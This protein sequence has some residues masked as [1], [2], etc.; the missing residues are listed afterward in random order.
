MTKLKVGMISL[1]CNKN[2]VDSETA[3]GLLREHGYEL[4]NDPAQ[5]DVLMVNTC[6]FIASAKEESIDAIL[7]MARYKQIGKCRVLLFVPREGAATVLATYERARTMPNT[8]VDIS[9]Y[10][11]MLAANLVDVVRGC[12]RLGVGLC[13]FT[14]IENMLKEEGAEDIACLPAE[15]LVEALRMIKEPKEIAALR[16]VAAFTDECMATICDMLRPGVTQWEVEN[17]LNQLGLEHGCSDVPFSPSCTFTKTGDPRCQDKIGTIPKDEP[18]TPGTAIAFDNGFVMDG[19]CSDYGRSFYCG[20]APR[21]IAD[22]YKALQTAQLELLDHIKPGVSMSCTF[23]KLHETLSRLGYGE[24]LRNFANIGMMGHQIG[25]DVHEIPWL[26]NTTPEVFQP[27]M[28]M[29]IE[30]KLWL[31]G[32]AF[33]RTEDMVL[34]TE[35]GCESLTVFDRNWYELP[36]E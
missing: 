32:E 13:A 36:L 16:R 5:A 4:T 20:P 10:Y 31:P 29:C 30:P 6:G 25:I 8:P 22:A 1:G 34:I 21:H 35:T 33:M 3:L 24:N 7:D 15:G 26:H 2:R 11:V 28:V 12:K 18:L 23:A 27:G 19:Y 17:R 9:C 14:A